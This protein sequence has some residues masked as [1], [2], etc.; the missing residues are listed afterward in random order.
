MLAL[1]DQIYAG[2][3]YTEV[4]AREF[5]TV[6]TERLRIALPTA[7]AVQLT[8][9]V[10][11]IALPPRTI[12]SLG[13]LVNELFTNSMK[14]AFKAQQ[15]GSIW[16]SLRR[17]GTEYVL[18][19]QD[20]GPGLSQAQTSAGFGTTLIE[21]LAEQLGARWEESGPPGVRYRFHFPAGNE[22]R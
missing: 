3:H 19:Y 8:L 9:D 2:E 18:K 17:E 12:S 13:Q 4:P 21:A 1:Y 7:N 16:V 6:L 10:E 5:L 20:D 11:E 22:P 14:H 15:A